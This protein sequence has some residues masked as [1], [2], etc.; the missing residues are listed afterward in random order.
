MEADEVLSLALTR[1]VEII[2]EAAWQI[3]DEGKSRCPD[4]PWPQIIG[5]RHRIVHAYFAI[6]YA[7]LWKTVQESLP[8]LA[9]QIRPVLRQWERPMSER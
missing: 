7:I 8:D 9:A 1:L 2:G 6:N 4:M 3:T 5:M